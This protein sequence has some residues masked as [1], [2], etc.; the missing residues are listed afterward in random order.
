MCLAKPVGVAKSSAALLPNPWVNQPLQL[1]TQQANSY[2]YFYGTRLCT[3]H[4]VQAN[5]H[6][7]YSMWCT[8]WGAPL[9][10]V[11]MSCNALLWIL[12]SA[13]TRHA[14]ISTEV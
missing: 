4:R 5:E 11:L 3:L 7:L 9:A 14:C 2:G 1:G 10:L 13:G 8:A 12:S 6:M